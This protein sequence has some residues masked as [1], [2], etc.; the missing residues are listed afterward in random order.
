MK[1][2]AYIHFP[3][4]EIA[5]NHLAGNPDSY[6]E[7]VKELYAIKYKLK[8]NSQ[9]ELSYDWNNVQRFL[10]VAEGIIPDK[11]LGGIRSQ[12]LHIVGTT[13]RNVS[14]PRLRIPHFTYTTWSID[15]KV[16][17]SPFVVSES[18]EDTL[19]DSATEKTICLCLGDSINAQRE[20]L[21]IIKDAIHD[22]TLPK[23]I[24]VNATSSDVGFVKWVTTL[25]VGKFTLRNNND[26]EP[27]EKFWG[28]TKERIFRHKATGNHWYFDFN[29]KDNKIHYEV[30]D[31]TGNTHLGEADENGTLKAETQSNKKKISDLL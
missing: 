25:P 9:Y 26:F 3:E 2:K 4:D 15:L 6:N 5:F 17:H 12:I 22:S 28:R 14:Q 7:I 19:N 16:A 23:L 30:F 11:Y 10:A 24:T 8:K 21:H 1:I 20:E 27:L 13:S 31:G 18:A 29:H